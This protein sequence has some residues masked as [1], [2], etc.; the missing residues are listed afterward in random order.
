MKRINASDKKAIAALYGSDFVVPE[1]V[2]DADRIDTVIYSGF[3]EP[4]SND[5]YIALNGIGAV[6]EDGKQTISFALGDT[7]HAAYAKDRRRLIYAPTKTPRATRKAEAP[8]KTTPTEEKE[9][10]FTLSQIY[11]IISRYGKFPKIEGFTPVAYRE[12]K[13]KELY[14]NTNSGTITTAWSG[15]GFIALVFKRNEPPVKVFTPLPE[16]KEPAHATSTKRGC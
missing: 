2:L 10:S 8:Q 4:K 13:N 9:P 7:V 3:R 1:A 15:G 12:V 16:R 6:F 11:E 5:Q 14:Y